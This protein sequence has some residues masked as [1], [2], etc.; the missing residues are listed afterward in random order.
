VGQHHPNANAHTHSDA[1]R[2]ADSIT[3]RIT[4]GNRER[5]TDGFARGNIRI[6]ARVSVTD[7]NTDA[8]RHAEPK[9]VAFTAR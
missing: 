9:R 5:L 3:G 4:I 6:P 2:N 7:R 8:D 1:E